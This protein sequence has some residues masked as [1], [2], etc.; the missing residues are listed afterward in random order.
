MGKKISID[1]ANLMNKILEIIEASLIFNLPISKFK[2][3]IHPESLIHAIIQYSNGLSTMLY[4]INDMKIPIANS[5]GSICYFKN[6]NNKFV[7]NDK[8]FKKF[9]FCRVKKEMFP[10]IKILLMNKILFTDIIHKLLTI[11]KSSIVK[12][13]LKK[14]KIRH[15]ADIFITYNFCKKLLAQ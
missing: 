3:V 2:I 11:L 15:I 14:H 1:S 6:I 9:N 13:H 7:F 8:F 4:H 5:I 12:N 10:C